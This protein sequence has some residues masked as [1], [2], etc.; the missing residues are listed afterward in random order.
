MNKKGS[1]PIKDW[2]KNDRIRQTIETNMKPHLWKFFEANIENEKLSAEPIESVYVGKIY[3]WRDGRNAWHS[4]WI[5]RYDNLEAFCISEEAA[6]NRIEASRVQGSVFYLQEFP[7]LTFS[8][9]SACLLIGE[10]SSTSPL[11][12]FKSIKFSDARSLGD[13]ATLLRPTGKNQ[14]IRIFSSFFPRKLD[15]TARYPG[16]KSVGGGSELGYVVAKN[17]DIEAS[18]IYDVCDSARDA[19]QERKSRE[20]REAKL[21][22]LLTKKW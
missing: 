10:I 2:S 17:L 12:V 22:T 9:K 5:E 16:L 15:R 6:K 20:A 11:S 18:D 19:I 4:T 14:T 7:V 8:G 3:Y 13:A 21:A 1:E